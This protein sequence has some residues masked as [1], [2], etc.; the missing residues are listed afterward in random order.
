MA[1]TT[2]TIQNIFFFTLGRLRRFVYGFVCFA[3][4]IRANQLLAYT[5]FYVLSTWALLT[6]C[7]WLY[8]LGYK[9]HIHAHAY[10][11]A[12]TFV[13]V[14]MPNW[15]FHRVFMFLFTPVKKKKMFLL[16]L[17]QITILRRYVSFSNLPVLVFVRRN[18]SFFKQLPDPHVT[19]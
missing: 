7:A 1:R 11:Q 8:S 10:M 14:N 6:P 18:M 9:T 3:H 13:Y 4:T 2:Q 19:K 12:H 17:E 15:L 5:I 16:P